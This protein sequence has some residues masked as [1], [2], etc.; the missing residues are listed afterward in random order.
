MPY[1]NWIRDEDLINAVKHIILTAQAAKEKSEVKFHRNVIDPF[2]ALFQIT[3]FN[4]DGAT[5]L[6]S[7]KTRQAE[8]ALQ[9]HIG[10]FHQKILG[11][12]DGWRNLGIGGNM[13]LKSDERRLLAEV[14]NKHNTV[15]G[16]SLFDVYKNLEGLVM[17]NSSIYNGYTAYFVQII[18]KRPERYNIPFTPS[19]RKTST[20]VHA[21]ELIRIIDGASFYELVTG[22]EHALKDLF[23]VIPDVIESITERNLSNHDREVMNDFFRKAYI[24]DN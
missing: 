2:S 8:K 13:D 17:P 3:G 15:T 10:D 4:L 20:R 12:V 9:N 7:E 21:N 18:P 5:W 6:T 11:E 22:E 1:L 16:G 23:D 19:N 24:G 14:K